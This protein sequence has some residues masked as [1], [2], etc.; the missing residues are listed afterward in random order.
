[1]LL[2]L[3]LAVACGAAATAVPQAP[4]AAPQAPAAGVPPAAKPAAASVPNPAPQPKVTRLVLGIPPPTHEVNRPWLTSGSGLVQH[5]PWADRLIGVDVVSGQFVPTQMATKWE[6]SPDGKKWTF[7][8]RENIPFHFGYGNFTAQDLEHSVAMWTRKEAIQTRTDY[9][10]E[11]V[12]RFERIND[13]QV[14]M[15]LKQ[16]DVAMD[17]IMSEFKNQTMLSKAQWDK[18]GDEGVERK[19]AGTGSWR[20]LGR[21]SGAYVRYERV[22]NHWRK[23]PEFKEIELRWVPE[24]STRLA[25]LLANESHIADVPRELEAQ[26]ISK[27]MKKLEGTMPGIQ[28]TLYFGG[29]F[30]SDKEYDPQVPWANPNTGKLVREAM[31][32]A[33]NRKQLNATIFQSEGKPIYVWDYHS[34]FV[35]MNPRWEKEFE[36]KY[37]YDPAKAK[38]LL[39]EA[40]YPNGFKVKIFAYLQSGFPELPEVSE[41]VA[42]YFGNIGLDASIESADFA[43]V[44]GLY[45][46]K[47]NYQYVAPHRSSVQD[48]SGR[49]SNTL[50]VTNFFR[51][52]YL[53]DRFDQSAKSI[54]RAERQ[55]LFLEIGDRIFDEYYAM[56][57]YFLPTKV[58]ANPQIVS[59][60]VWPGSFSGNYTHTEYIQAA[61]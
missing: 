53:L 45:R 61:R 27:G 11:R 59:G 5:N 57:L 37:G 35:Q 51:E 25:Q 10:R 26:A 1:M 22:D 40:G 6:M 15:H 17:D 28:T 19:P 16:P 58:V 4:A 14:V 60:W 21:E 43:V 42:L 33:V 44:R 13:H 49:L 38:A 9:L 52:Q 46:D 30:F 18:E 31:N 48:V 39:K 7:W 41:A 36:A 8:L 12:E 24:A 54:D 32:R 29:L 47:K 23:T 50:T 34:A 20:Y 56:P 55:R 3:L 2:V